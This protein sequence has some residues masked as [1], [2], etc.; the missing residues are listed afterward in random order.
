MKYSV[1]LCYLTHN[2]PDVIREVFDNSLN[3]YSS[4]GIDVF[5]YDDSDD[6]QTRNIVWRC[7]A[8]W[9]ASLVLS[10]RLSV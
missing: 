2:H 8:T 9:R 5:V 3:A 10:S 7:G 1:A 4:H 6:E